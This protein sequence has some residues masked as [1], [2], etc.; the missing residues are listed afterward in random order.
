M[1][2]YARLVAAEELASA[3]CRHFGASESPFGHVDADQVVGGLRSALSVQAAEAGRP[4]HLLPHTSVL[5]AM[6]H[7][8]G[9]MSYEHE[10][11]TILSTAYGSLHGGPVNAADMLD[12]FSRAL[13]P[14]QMPRPATVSKIDLKAAIVAWVADRSRLS[15][16]GPSSPPS[17]PKLSSVPVGLATPRSSP[18]GHAAA[19]AAAAAAAAYEQHTAYLSTSTS[20]MSSSLA[21]AAAAAAAASVQASTSSVDPLRVAGSALSTLIAQATAAAHDHERALA[22]T[23]EA[24]LGWQNR[25]NVAEAEVSHLTAAKHAVQ[26]ELLVSEQER[27]A[28]LARAAALEER[29]RALEHERQVGALR[30]RE[31]EAR[32]LE[33]EAQLA[34]RASELRSAQQV[35][36]PP[37]SPQSHPISPQSRP[38]LDLALGAAGQ[39][40][41]HAAHARTAHHAQDGARRERDGARPLAFAHVRLRRLPPLTFH[42]PSIGLPLASL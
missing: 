4:L 10:L 29:T 6:R 17:P 14:P 3:I 8:V 7:F 23:S 30:E 12:G 38:D 18:P 19:T 35:R 9:P 11:S 15:A 28:A 33:L 27:Q 34:G 24:A 40:L 21:R 22:A 16:R 25:A 5:S 41:I 37:I 42:R 20:P 39:L 26:S 32:A 1:S 2:E 36:S 13:A 31:A